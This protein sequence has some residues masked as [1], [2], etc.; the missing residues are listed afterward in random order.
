[1]IPVL[2]A[3]ARIT[4]GGLEVAIVGA[5]NPHIAPGRGDRERADA[6]QRAPV[7]H[8]ITVGMAVVK[9]LAAAPAHDAGRGIGDVPQTRCARAVV[10]IAVYRLGQRHGRAGCNRR[11]TLPSGL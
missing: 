10:R 1:V 6:P 11:A 4:A 5:A 3:L 9:G 7:A 2:L 8:G